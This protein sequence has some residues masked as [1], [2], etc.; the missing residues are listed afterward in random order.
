MARKPSNQKR[1]EFLRTALR[2]FVQNG[3]QGT[4]TADIT[5]EAGTA[6]GTLFLYFP[7]KLDLVNQLTLSTAREQTIAINQ[8]LTPNLVAKEMLYR[9]WHT[10][11]T[12]FKNHL[13]A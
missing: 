11:I 6:A 7:S 10:S 13:E 4:S 5:K 1:D 2:L 8:A 12:W 9:I 3:V